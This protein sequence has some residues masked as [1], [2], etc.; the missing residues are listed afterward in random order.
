MII[1]VPGGVNTTTN[2]TNPLFPGHQPVGGGV[3]ESP[4]ALGC[5]CNKVVLLLCVQAS[6]CHASVHNKP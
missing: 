4:I 2:P 5:I 1:A 6:N 3:R